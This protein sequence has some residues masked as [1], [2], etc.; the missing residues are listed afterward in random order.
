MDMSI[1][2]KL[3]KS[4]LFEIIQSGEKLA[5]PLIKVSIPL[6]ENLQAPLATVAPVPA[7]D[8]AMSQESG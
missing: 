7:V 8:G 4:K 2:I 1:D 6:T 3:S 5:G